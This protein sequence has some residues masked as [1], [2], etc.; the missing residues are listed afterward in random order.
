MRESAVEKYLVLRVSEN[1]GRAE[2]FTSPNR[3]HVPDRLVLWPG[4][5]AEFVELK[6]LGK[7]PTVMQA[8]DHA[9]RRAMGFS[10]FVLDSIGAVDVYIHISKETRA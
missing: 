3:A 5:R 9:R 2:K 10:V 8:R 4:G 6:A 1:G 7:I